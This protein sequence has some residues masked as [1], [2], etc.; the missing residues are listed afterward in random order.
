M[1]PGFLPLILENPVA[2]TSDTK[3]RLPHSSSLLVLLLLFLLLKLGGLSA[4]LANNEL[5]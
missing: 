4:K 1:P 5:E 2:E 3:W